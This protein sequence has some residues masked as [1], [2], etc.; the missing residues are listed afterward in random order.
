[1]PAQRIGNACTC[2][3]SEALPRS[4]SNNISE[5]PHRRVGQCTPINMH[6][7]MCPNEATT[8][9]WLKGCRAQGRPQAAM[10]QA[11]DWHYASS[12]FAPTPSSMLGP[13]TGGYP[14]STRCGSSSAL[15]S[16]ALGFNIAGAN[17]ADVRLLSAKAVRQASCHGL[18]S[19]AS[20]SDRPRPSLPTRKIWT[21]S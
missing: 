21:G 1:M 15:Q 3:S 19:Y 4:H 8:S 13:Y 6:V 17:S 9:T 2:A 7:C 20:R 11:S 16:F 5:L 10:M 14:K 18:T 12:L